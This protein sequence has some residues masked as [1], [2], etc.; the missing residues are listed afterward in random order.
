MH[1]A[2]T[3]VTNFMKTLHRLDS[4]KVELCKSLVAGTRSE[5]GE[6]DKPPT[7]KPE[8]SVS[9]HPEGQTTRRDKPELQDLMEDS[10]ISMANLSEIETPREQEEIKVPEVS[11]TLIEIERMYQAGRS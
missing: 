10:L 6:P 9:A 8:V 1:I 2:Q 5:P 7:G 3:D 11:K 4:E